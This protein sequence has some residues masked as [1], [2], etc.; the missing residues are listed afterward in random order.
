M[1]TAKGDKNRVQLPHP[2]I[3]AAS[4]VGHALLIDDGKVKLTVTSKGDSWLYCRVDVPGKIKDRKGVNTPDC[5]LDI[6]PMTPKDRSDLEYMLKIGVDW[7]ALSFVQRPSDIEEMNRLIDTH[8]PQGMFRPAV[9][10]KIEKPS[11]FEGDTLERLVELCNGIMV[12]RGD[13]GVECPPE[14]VPLLQ[15]T[16]I[17]ECRRQGKPVIVAT[18]MLES[19]IESPTPTRAEAS[20]CAT[21]IYDGADAIML[22]YVDCLG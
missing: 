19:M 13:L 10:A 12:A 18:Q 5:I 1:D 14:D 6:S 16:I 9:L 8:L 7:V 22:R 11:C 3:I 20:D 17:D 15:K 21:A 4:Q 2:E